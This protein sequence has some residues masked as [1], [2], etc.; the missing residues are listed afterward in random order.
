MESVLA[1]GHGDG[2]NKLRQNGYGARPSAGKR[3][4]A[5]LA[6]RTGVDGDGSKLLSLVIRL[7]FVVYLAYFVLIRL[8]SYSATYSAFFLL[9]L[10]V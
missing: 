9:H 7:V 8:V 4:A 3:L 2:G 1:G 6:E 5:T 10:N